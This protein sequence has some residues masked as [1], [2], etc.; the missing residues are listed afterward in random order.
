MLRHLGAVHRIHNE[1]IQKVPGRM[2]GVSQRQDVHRGWLPQEGHATVNQPEER[3]LI[4]LVLVAVRANQSPPLPC[5]DNHCL[6]AML[7]ITRLHSI[8]GLPLTTTH[9]PVEAA[10][11]I[12]SGDLD[13]QVRPRGE[14]HHLRR[15]W[16][17]YS[18]PLCC[19][20]H[21]AGDP[22]LNGSISTT[23]QRLH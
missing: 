3:P 23:M 20:T 6:A 5:Q 7:S 21:A 18:C 14:Q 22:P 12:E 2:L 13:Q 4:L 11:R 16:V 15:P 8:L 19:A 9:H 1:L 10:V 17:G